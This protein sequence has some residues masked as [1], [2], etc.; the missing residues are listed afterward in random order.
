MS[1]RWYSTMIECPCERCSQRAQLLW[2]LA[3][4]RELH[5]G[6][7]KL[8]RRTLPSGPGARA[9]GRRGPG[10][11][12]S[13]L[14]EAPAGGGPHDGTLDYVGW[15]GRP[16][17]TH[18]ADTEG[19][20]QPTR[21]SIRSWSRV[22]D[23]IRF[24]GSLYQRSAL[25]GRCSMNTQR[26]VRSKDLS[27]FSRWEGRR[28]TSSPSARARSDAGWNARLHALHAARRQRGRPCLQGQG[29][30]PGYQGGA[31]HR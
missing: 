30:D 14:P 19:A 8:F 5:A 22:S 29:C 2:H 9:R 31:G 15:P 21:G 24:F 18:L 26:A 1:R 28:R 16:P 13:V 3:W 17:I 11:R 6:A 25:V 27:A 12:L 7:P 20:G 10:E 4:D 23:A